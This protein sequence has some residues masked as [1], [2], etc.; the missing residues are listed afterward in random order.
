[1]VTEQHILDLAAPDPTKFIE[2]FYSMRQEFT[3]DKD[4]Y[5]AVERI[6]KEA[7]QRTRYQN[8]ESFRRVKTRHT[9]RSIEAEKG[10]KE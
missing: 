1:M 6:F 3:T 7:F 8:F 5:V 2:K 9:K 10:P 4:C